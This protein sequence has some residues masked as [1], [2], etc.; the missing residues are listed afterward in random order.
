MI[1]RTRSRSSPVPR[2]VDRQFWQSFFWTALFFGSLM[3]ILTRVSWLSRPFAAFAF[4]AFVIWAY[5]RSL[6]AKLGLCA[7]RAGARAEREEPPRS[8]HG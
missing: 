5:R 7:R 1:A 6:G 8:L 4:L 3:A 2:Y